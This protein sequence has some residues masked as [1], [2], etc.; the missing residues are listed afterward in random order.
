MAF[1]VRKEGIN[2]LIGAIYDAALDDFQWPVVLGRLSGAFGATTSMLQVQDVRAGTTSCISSIGFSA[3]HFLQYGQHY[4]KL[5]LWAEGVKSLP[6]DS[7]HICSDLVPEK[8]FANSEIWN[9][10]GRKIGPG[11]YRAVGA[12]IALENARVALIGF[13]RP[14]DARD[15]VRSDRESL[16][17]LLPHL[18]RALQLRERLDVSLRREALAF[19][20]LET[21][22]VPLALAR[23]N[24][25]VIFANSAARALSALNDGFDLGDAGGGTA[26]ACHDETMA[27]RALI[28]KTALTG[29]G[30]GFG[31]GGAMNLSRP[32]KR[33]AYRVLVS[34]VTARWSGGEAAVLVLIVDPERASVAPSAALTQLF[35]L[36]SAEARLA[37]ALASGATLKEAS[38]QFGV[39]ILTVRAQLRMVF[40]K[41]RTSRQA[42]LVRLLSALSLVR[43]VS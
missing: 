8:A 40:S 22:A 11:V 34:P 9:E 2:E 16:E 25:S 32:S 24:G 29:A 19:D 41:T 10:Y 23:A 20:S 31:A 21:L 18:R 17:L 43:Q 36:T 7:A 26:S 35:G 13:H 37:L 1:G 4:W 3:D 42:E 30:R 39:S 38:V 28:A 33:G 14:R 27:L 5:D 6:L 12:T 15:F